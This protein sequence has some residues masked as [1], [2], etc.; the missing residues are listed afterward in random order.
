MWNSL[1]FRL[2]AIFIGIAIVPLIVVG[3]ILAQRTYSIESSQVLALQDQVAQ[4]ASSQ[5]DGYIQG[6]VTD[7]NSVGDEIRGLNQPDQSQLLSIMLTSLTSGP[8]QNVYEDLALLDAQGREKIVISHQRVVPVNELL[9][10][11]GKDE[12]ELPKSTRAVYFSPVWPDLKS[13]NL[14]ITIAIPLYAPRSVQLTG[15]LVATMRFA[16]IGNLLST[17]STGQ[18]ETIYVTDDKGN[19]V[20]HEDRS[21]NLLKAHIILPAKANIQSGLDGTNVA[22]GLTKLQIGAQTLNVIAE[23]PVADALSLAYIL[24]STL[25]IVTVAT[26]LISVALGA[27]AARQIVSPIELLAASSQRIAAGD[28]SQTTAVN[29]KDEIGTLGTAF[30]SMT[31]QLRDTLQGLEQRVSERT[32]D[33]EKQTLRLRTAAEVARD[34][35]SA[36]NLSELLSRS[37][38]LIWDR[39]NFYHAGIFLLDEKKEYAVLRAS[40]TEAGHKMI[41][42]GH[43]LKVGE[44][45][46]VGRVAATGEPRIALDAGADPVHFNNPLLPDTRSEMALPLKS[47]SGVIGVLDVQSE[48][49][50]AFTQDDIAIL[51]VMADQLSAAI[52]RTRLLQQ[53]ENNLKDLEKAYTAFT[54][55]SWNSFS[56]AGSHSLGYR[57]NN[58]RLEPIYEIP[59]DGA[60]RTAKGSLTGPEKEAKGSNASIP[61]R[62]R[63]QTIGFVNV[64]FQG[65]YAPQEI[66]SM[67]EQASDRLASALENARLVEETRQRSQRDTLVTEM[68]GRFRS[69]L[70]LESVLR[71]AAQELQQAFQLSEAEVRLG[72]PE[73]VEP[74]NKPKAK[75]RKK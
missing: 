41:E 29:R 34:A 7:L 48:Q 24:I 1:R 30:N 67:M 45:G 61:I 64:R 50:E 9:S 59:A 40:P 25:V 57:Y 56:S 4:N 14:F 54:D 3:V 46:I 62:L 68:T 11:A 38:H 28:L 49:P 51:Q 66:I 15:V 58:I 63:G 17:V 37:S 35:A 23:K 69:T 31:V 19:V 13:G 10:Q 16:A 70:D 27:L 60:G 75:P 55:K 52:E 65:E 32:Q 39:F 22:L 42:N 36:P 6:V 12:F 53:V 71:T 72:L 33:L 20:A 2:T 26:L 5:I 43:R 74:D 8:Y 44:Q 21:V 73:T 18:G 47:N